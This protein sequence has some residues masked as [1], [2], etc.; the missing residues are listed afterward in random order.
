MHIQGDDEPTLF[1]QKV[2]KALKGRKHTKEHIEKIATAR[3]Y[4]YLAINPQ[5]ELI[6][7]T[8]GKKFAKENNL[9]S[10]GIFRCANHKQETSQGWMFYHIDDPI[11]IEIKWLYKN[12]LDSYNKVA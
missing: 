1:G 2:S 9:Y 4:S 11:A 7:F 5:G 10:K 12:V 8:G 6:E 3:R